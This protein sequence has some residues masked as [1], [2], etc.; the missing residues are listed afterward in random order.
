MKT[1]E[2]T[3]Y[4]INA[5]YALSNEIKELYKLVEEEKQKVETL[6]I[7]LDS[8]EVSCP[9]RLKIKIFDIKLNLIEKLRY[10]REIEPLIE[11]AEN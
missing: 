2:Y 6:N 4:N 10:D 11:S 8:L 1:A 3:K 7:S 5:I 9:H